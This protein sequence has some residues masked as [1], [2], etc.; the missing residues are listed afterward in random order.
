VSLPP[1]LA[2]RLAL[3]AA[4]AAAACVYP[5]EHDADVHVS[6]T[7]LPILIRG[8]DTLATARAWQL[9]GTGDSVEITNV[10]FV[11]SSGN[12]AVATVD[13]SG[14][15]VGIKSGTTTIRAAAANFDKRS[16]P[17]DITLRVA[18]R[19]EIDSI[20]P[21]KV[22]FGDTITVYG[23]GVDSIFQA[24][25]GQGVL[26]PNVFRRSRDAN[27]YARS[28][29]WVPPPARR[30]SLFYIGNGVF[31]FSKDTVRVIQQ[32]L[33]ETPTP[34][35]DAAPAILDLDGPRPFP[36]T[37]FASVLF[38]NPALAFEV[39][40][41]D[42]LV[43]GCTSACGVDWYRLQQAGTRDL[44]IIIS[45]PEVKGTFAG[46]VSNGFGAANAWTVGPG[47]HNCRGK[48]FSPAEATGDSMIVALAGMPGPGLDAIALFT[49]HGRYS[50]VVAEGYLT[51]DSLDARIVKDAHEEDDYCDA[52]GAMVTEAISPPYRA[53]L[54]IDNPHDVDWI[55]FNVPGSLVTPVQIR[56]GAVPIVVGQDSSDI[57][58]YVLHEPSAG[59]QLDSIAG[60]AAPG[61]DNNTTVLLAPGNYYAVV[62]DFA[63]VPTPYNICIGA[64]LSSCAIFP[65]PPAPAPTPAQLQAATRRR[66]ALEARTAALRAARLRD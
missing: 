4:A 20:R 16:Q 37:A 13:P 41:R 38:L 7:P 10:S 60:V 28:V 31:G 12:S 47:S 65:A 48:K 46:F 30:D 53:A 40:P 50:L 57:D 29:Y 35:H 24:Q 2:L 32:D 36:G 3:C 6:V 27:G 59:A 49:Q 15:I 51:S 52:P 43:P 63:G 34:P 26:I 14:H 62:V 25:L 58:V 54:T 8:N 22:H 39:L 1:R 66:A 56:T 17:G 33:Y 64:G 18:E 9:V 61:S 45:A 21:P 11:W 5:T 55:R 19:L 42:S 44:T 23:V